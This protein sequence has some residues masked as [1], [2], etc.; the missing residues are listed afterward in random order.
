VLT[1][2]QA[3]ISP[4]PASATSWSEPDP[5]V[6]RG[7]RAHLQPPAY[8][9][10]WMAQAAL[11]RVAPG[12]EIGRRVGND[13]VSRTGAWMTSGGTSRWAFS[14]AR[15]R[16]PSRTARTSAKPPALGWRLSQLDVSVRGLR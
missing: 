2:G 15:F 8:G 5:S 10:S 7:Y 9:A 13:Q 12:A 14:G 11:E 4:E 6:D 1:A 16:T 3:Q